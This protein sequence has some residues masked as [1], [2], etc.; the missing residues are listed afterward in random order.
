MEEAKAELKALLKDKKANYAKY[1]HDV[2]KPALS[3]S[4]QVEMQNLKDRLKH[5]V[6]AS[7]RISPGQAMVS[8]S[9]LNRS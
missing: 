2:H 8:F 6:R 7:S 9:R 5:P 3:F 1:V 4:K